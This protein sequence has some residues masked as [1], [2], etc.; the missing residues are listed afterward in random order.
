MPKFYSED[1]VREILKK[2]AA[3][4]SQTQLAIDLGVSLAFVNDAIHGR[5]NLSDKLANAL[6]YEKVT[7]YRKVA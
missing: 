7:V 2:R 5:R 4:A 1:H 3:A 6:G